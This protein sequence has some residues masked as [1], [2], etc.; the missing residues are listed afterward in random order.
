MVATEDEMIDQGTV[1]RLGCRRKPAGCA[2]VGIAGR[3]IAARVVVREDNSRAAMYRRVAND[4]AQWETRSG[5]VAIMSR[6][7]EAARLLVDVRH[8]DGFEARVQTRHA[9]SEK[10]PRCGKA[11]QS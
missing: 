5:T 10:L 8:P 2:A 9:T 6:Q 11:V 4:L 7:M 1:Q 3:R